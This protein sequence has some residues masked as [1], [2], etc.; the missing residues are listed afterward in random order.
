[1]SLQDR[2]FFGQT[3]KAIQLLLLPVDLRNQ[4]MSVNN[5]RFKGCNPLQQDLL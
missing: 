3:F 5:L 2:V 1:L 4:P